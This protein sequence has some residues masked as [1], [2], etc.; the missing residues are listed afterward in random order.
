MSHRTVTNQTQLDQALTDKVAE[1]V[2]DSPAGVWLTVRDTGSSRVEARG[3]SRVVASGS[4]RVEA[5][6]SSRVEASGSSRVEARGS[7]RVVAWDSSHVVAWDSSRVEAWDSSRVVARGSSHVVAWDSSRVEAWDSSHVEAWDSSHVEAG[8]YVAVHLHSQRVTLTGG[9]VIDMTA[10][11][12]SDPQTWADLYGGKVKRGRLTVYKGVDADLRSAHGTTYPI[13]KTVTAPDW[14]P[15]ADCGQGLHFSPSPI[16]T[17]SYC[18]PQRYL[19]CTV[20][21]ADMVPLGDK[22]KARSCR[23]VREVDR[24]GDPIEEQS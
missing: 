7:S 19:E 23:V 4:S 24:F 12:R 8:K 16:A 2:I 22:V 1:I 17:E 20:A 18:D 14:N 6:G 10:L 13:G 21:L 11:D 9:V 3:S 5:S 15:V